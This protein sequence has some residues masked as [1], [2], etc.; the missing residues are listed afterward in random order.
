M[1]K[2]LWFYF[3]TVLV[4]TGYAL[5]LHAYSKWKLYFTVG[6]VAFVIYGAGLFI[7]MSKKDRKTELR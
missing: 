1:A 4:C 2:E 3:T 6:L 7:L 5:L